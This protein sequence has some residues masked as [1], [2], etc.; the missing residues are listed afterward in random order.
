MM[1]KNDAVFGQI[2]IKKKMMNK[3]TQ[4]LKGLGVW[5]KW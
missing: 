4:N 1:I 2:L 3:I 5:L